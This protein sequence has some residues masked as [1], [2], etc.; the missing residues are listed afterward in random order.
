MDRRLLIGFARVQVDRKKVKHLVERT[1]LTGW[2]V[3]MVT[4]GER[5]RAHWEKQ[6]VETRPGASLEDIEAFQTRY[7]VIL[8]KDMRDYVTAVDGMKDGDTDEDMYSFKSLRDVKSV[9]EDF[10][11]DGEVPD[12]Y[13]EC[14]NALEA[15]GKFFVIIDY[16]IYSHIY[17]ILLSSDPSKA[18]PVI[19][20]DGCRSFDI[21]PSFS[22]FAENYLADPRKVM[23]PKEL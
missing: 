1:G 15:R 19:W 2:T 20:T 4:I 12:C 5:I 18:G 11:Q 22:A 23:F 7:D 9:V 16:M 6:S 13:R 8:P 3:K 17:A 10:G 21:A 14:V